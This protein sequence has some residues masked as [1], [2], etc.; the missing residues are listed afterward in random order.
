MLTLRHQFPTNIAY[1]CTLYQPACVL[2]AAGLGA[3]TNTSKEFSTE[4][5]LLAPTPNMRVYKLENET[6]LERLIALTN[7]HHKK[8]KNAQVHSRGKRPSP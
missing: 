7:E 4:I 2:V 1:D 6:Q 8:K 3:D 5:W